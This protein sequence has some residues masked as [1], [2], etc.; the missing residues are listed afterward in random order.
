MKLADINAM[1]EARF[2]A[3]LGDV[4]EHSP[5]VAAR[6]F[7]HKPFGE[8]AQL[9]DAM[10]TVVKS[11]SEAEQLALIRAHPDLAGK[12]ALAGELTDASTLEQASAGLDRLSEREYR[13]FHDLNT[14]YCDKFGFPFIIAVKD[15]TKDTILDSFETRL[16]NDA[17]AELATALENILRITELRLNAL[18][19]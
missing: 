6:A 19:P 11:A 3:T 5:W 8:I 4:F 14:R 16:E 13:R 9:H 12:A 1:D 17:P 10:A 7:A 2:T 15:H 18:L